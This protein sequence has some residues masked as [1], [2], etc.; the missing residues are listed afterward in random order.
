MLG[1][2]RAFILVWWVVQ[3]R[4]RV[5]AALARNDAVWMA[6]SRN[7]A[8]WVGSTRNDAVLGGS[9]AMTLPLSG[10]PET[11]KPAA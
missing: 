1:M 9:S 3:N 7:D 10:F 5:S 11:K 2:A 6:I 4:F 8:V